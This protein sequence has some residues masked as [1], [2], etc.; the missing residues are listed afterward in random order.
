MIKIRNSIEPIVLFALG[1]MLIAGSYLVKYQFIS[2]VIHYN[3]YQERTGIISLFMLIYSIFFFIAGAFSVYFLS[4][5]I[6]LKALFIERFNEVIGFIRKFFMDLYNYGFSAT[7]K[8][9]IVGAIITGLI[10]RA[11][12]VAAPMRAD[13]SATFYYF[14]QGPLY[15]SF[16]YLEPNNHVLHT[17]FARFMVDVF[18]NNQFALRFPAFVAG[19]LCIPLIFI[20]TQRLNGK[21]SGFV[22]IALMTIFPAILIFDTMARGY[23][24]VN[25]FLLTGV[26]VGNS[27]INENTFSRTLIFALNTALGI[28]VMPTFLFP[29]FGLYLWVAVLLLKKETSIL[30][31]IRSFAIPSMIMLVLFTF[32]FY[33]PVILVTNNIDKLVSNSTI[34]PLE[35][36]NFLERTPR[37]F[38]F[39][40]NFLFSDI[41]SPLK[42]L[43]GVIFSLGI[44]WLVVKRKF[45]LLLLM[46]AFVLGAAILYFA[47]R[48][49]PFARTWLYLF[50]A[51]FMVADAGV[52]YLFFT[53]KKRWRF[54]FHAMI[55][56][57]MIATGVFL[58]NNDTVTNSHFTESFREAK[59]VATFL[60]AKIKN[61]DT[62]QMD[63]P[64]DYSVRYYLIQNK[65]VLNNTPDSNYIPKRYFV[66]K[67]TQNKLVDFAHQNPV[68][69]FEL[70][71]AEIYMAARDTSIKKLFAE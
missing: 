32:L 66:I 52:S 58:I 18:G 65:V 20:V 9:W 26:I 10:I 45:K 23:S 16:I 49:I 14:V 38:K 28:F 7:E 33:T 2:Q 48:S 25:F 71:E 30:R 4:K 44:I 43:F 27:M 8:I 63:H 41:Q 13:E 29:A 61:G 36:G 31:V 62:L 6:S 19:I 5:G 54:I 35:W 22:A 60:S 70:G 42:I 67:K 69:I 50:P 15:K 68:K 53:S 12:F 34:Q 21:K 11:Y 51:I 57:F 39:S 64:V 47:K 59:P 55:F 24:L 17:L 1:F 40:L 56:I 46:G 37:H 3:K